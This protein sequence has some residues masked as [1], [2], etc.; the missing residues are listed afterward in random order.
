MNY[1]F[2]NTS[3]Y[4]CIEDPFVLDHNVAYNFRTKNVYKFLKCIH[5]INKKITTQNC[6]DLMVNEPINVIIIPDLYPAISFFKTNLTF[7]S[8]SQSYQSIE[9]MN[10]SNDHNWSWIIN[11]FDDIIDCL[12]KDYFFIPFNKIKHEQELVYQ[13][14]S[15]SLELLENSSHF[16]SLEK[17]LHFRQS[18]EN[19]LIFLKTFRKNFKSDW[20]IK[21][22]LKALDTEIQI[23]F[24]DELMGNNF[25]YFSCFIN[26][27]EYSILTIIITL[28]QKFFYYIDRSS[29]EFNNFYNDFK[30]F[31]L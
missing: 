31:I 21:K 11:F 30:N 1:T 9:R 12:L 6:L 4:F 22:D 10:A 23:V 3:S 29:E 17:F 15:Q 8:Q 2:F 13:I 7:N 25:P 26:T 14:T 28:L 16:N 19:L 27:N 18:N 24:E 5:I 20:D